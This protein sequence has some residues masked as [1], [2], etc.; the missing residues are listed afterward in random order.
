TLPTGALWEPIGLWVGKHIL[1][2]GDVPIIKETGSGDTTLA[3]VLGFTCL[4]IS[5]VATVI[6]SLLDRKRTNYTKLYQWL[7]LA[8]RFWL[9]SFMTVYGASKVFP[10]QMPTPS[11]IKL[12]QQYGDFSPMG[13]LWNFIGTSTTYQ[14]F[15]G[16]VELLGGL[17]L[18]ARS[19]MLLGSVISLAAMTQVFILNMC[20][21]VPVKLFS[22]HLLLAALFLL[23]PHMTRL[24]DFFV[25]NRKIEPIKAVPL[26]NRE[27]LN[28]GVVIIQ[29]LVGLYL[30]GVSLLSGYE[31]HRTYNLA[32]KPPLYG[33]YSVEDFSMDDA[34]AQLVNSNQWKRII[35]ETQDRLYIQ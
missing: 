23:V 16:C 8:I 21:D 25:L 30:L 9:V 33:I 34:Q 31:S 13:I 22:F 28:R 11:L 12:V 19:T 14:V 6:W 15:T 10:V 26:F 4:L 3:Y 29:Y 32:P 1:R 2:L 27:R 24:V 5:V 20:Y 35:F 17:L 18:I 7:K